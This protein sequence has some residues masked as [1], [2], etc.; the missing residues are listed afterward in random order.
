MSGACLLVV[1]VLAGL[2]LATP[3][4]AQVPDATPTPG[5]ER[6][7]G[8]DADYA[9]CR[10]PVCRPAGTDADHDYV[11]CCEEVDGTDADYA[12]ACL[13]SRGVPGSGPAPRRAAPA[14]AVRQLAAQ[15]LPMTGGEPL[16]LAA[17]GL[18][19]LLAGAGLR[20]RFDGQ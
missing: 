19:L 14:S 12:Y 17:A 5:C 7:A 16:A 20:L 11:N 4:P 15:T 18:G 6:G 3:A 8:T 1:A 9:D 10:E 13:E 2:V